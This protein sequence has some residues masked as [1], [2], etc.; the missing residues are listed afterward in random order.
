MLGS[1]LSLTSAVFFG[2][3]NATMRRAVL[4]GTVSQGMAISVPLGVPIFVIASLFAGSFGL[5]WEFS[6]ESYILLALGGIVH[7]VFGRYCN[8]RAIKAMGANLVRPVQQMNVIL[9]LGL[10]MWLLGEVLTPLRM[11]GIALVLIGPFIM[12]LD[13]KK[14]SAKMK[15]NN[16]KRQDKETHFVPNYKEGITY[17]FASALGFGS[18]AV[19]VRAAI[20]GYGP[21]AGMTAG[22]IAYGA[23]ALVV[24]VALTQPKC[25][26]DVMS[27]SRVTGKWFMLS[28][29]LIGV[30]QMLRFMALAVAPVSV[31]APIQ[32]TTVVFQV[33]FAWMINRDHEAFGFWVLI[34]ILSSLIGAVALTVSTEFVL[35]YFDLPPAIHEISKWTWP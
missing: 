32:Q 9:A 25:Y 12:L 30:S 33:I 7:F 19:F 28:A 34:G 3:N 15:A 29:L 22:I 27:M 1:L 35:T 14:F 5:L 6:S 13:R 21:T 16:A 26:Q 23:A 2:L 24:A 18:S 17:A 4:T 20:G 11:L 8:Y 10:A 31:V